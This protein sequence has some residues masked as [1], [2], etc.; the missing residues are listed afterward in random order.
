[1]RVN[2]ADLQ[3]VAEA[4]YLSEHR[5]FQPLLAETARLRAAQARL[6]AQAGAARP[7]LSAPGAMQLTGADLL[8]QAWQARSRRDLNVA[9]ARVLADSAEARQR[10]RRAL[11]RSEALRL[12]VEQAD[13]ADRKDRVNCQLGF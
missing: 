4:K 9:L 13:A 11:G 7:L 10:L 3:A 5:R 12:L 6:Q 1:M 2:L 8:W